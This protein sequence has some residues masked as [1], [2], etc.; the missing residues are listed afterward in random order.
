MND[1]NYVE[2]DSQTTNEVTME[3]I[4]GYPATIIEETPDIPSYMAF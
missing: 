1:Y 2:T 4:D 3:L